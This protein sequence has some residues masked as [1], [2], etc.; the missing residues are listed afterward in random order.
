MK[1]HANSSGRR[2]LL[3][4]LLLLF[5]VFAVNAQENPPIPIQVEVRTAQFL[6]FGSFVA[7][8]AGGNVSVDYT[9]A[10]AANGDIFLLN[11]GAGKSPA[12]FDVYA[13]PGTIVHLAIPPEITLTS[14][15]GGR[16]YLSINS[17]S[18]GQ[19]FV[20]S[21]PA[22]I[23]NEVFIGGSLRVPNDAEALP[24]KYNGNFTINF[25]HQ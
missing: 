21:A 17:F 5:T 2:S 11:V 16:I 7:G 3:L 18:T 8:P 14:D 1:I 19:T 25:I 6:N 4:S 12:L 13:N 20:T 23:P 10:R 9:G 15:T 24:G 22:G